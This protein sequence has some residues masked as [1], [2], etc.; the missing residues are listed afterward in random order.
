MKKK[1]LDAFA[2][3]Q[4]VG[5]VLK[6]HLENSVKSPARGSYVLEASPAHANMCLQQLRIRPTAVLLCAVPDDVLLQRARDRMRDPATGQTYLL[7]SK[8]PPELP[9]MIR[10]RLEPA[11]IEESAQASVLRYRKQLSEWLSASGS[12]LR[13]LRFQGDG[14]HS[15]ATVRPKM[16]IHTVLDGR[17]GEGTRDP[18][19]AAESVVF[20]DVAGPDGKSVSSDGSAGVGD[21]TPLRQRR[22]GLG[23]SDL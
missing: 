5:K 23:H 18:S 21:M 6:K 4:L 16:Y 8:P 19:L 1:L 2:L 14:L 7:S 11:E 22:V 12:S 20:T 13:I 15:W 10:A 17:A 9:A 3:V